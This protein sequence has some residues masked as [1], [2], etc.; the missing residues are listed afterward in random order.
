[1]QLPT[2]DDE[3]FEFISVLQSRLKPES[4]WV[5]D[6]LA[7]RLMDVECLFCS[8]ETENGSTVKCCAEYC[9]DLLLA[10]HPD[11]A[12]FEESLRLTSISEAAKMEV[13]DLFEL[14]AVVDVNQATIQQA[15]SSVS[16]FFQLVFTRDFG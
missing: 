5:T 15:C 3:R 12:D 13:R 8:G 10:I 1:M 6:F 11:T 4:F 14:D 7:L 16:A 2:T 9:R